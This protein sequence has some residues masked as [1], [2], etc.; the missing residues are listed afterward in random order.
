MFPRP[1]HYRGDVLILKCTLCDGKSA[2]SIDKILKLISYNPSPRGFLK[3]NYHYSAITVCLQH[4]IKLYEYA[5][6][7]TLSL[8]L[9]VDKSRPKPFIVRNP[10]E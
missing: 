10:Y 1:S 3:K 5:M 8:T 6:P 2:S 9:P 4:F 7:A